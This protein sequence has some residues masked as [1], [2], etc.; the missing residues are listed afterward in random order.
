MGRLIV[1]Q[2]DNLLELDGFL[3]QAG[4]RAEIRVIG[5]W[6]PGI[7]ARDKHGW[8]FL[9]SDQVEIRLQTGLVTRLPS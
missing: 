9:T 4:D 6:I 8:Y 3:L 2:K 1:H 5:C 7:I